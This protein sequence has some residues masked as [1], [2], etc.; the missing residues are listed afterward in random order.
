[1][2]PMPPQGHGVH[3]YIFTLYA[4]D[5]E[6]GLKDGATKNQIMNAMKGHILEEAH[7]TGT[8]ERKRFYETSILTA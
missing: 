4:L 2:G 5:M 8:F 6:L 7:L 3:R 1:M